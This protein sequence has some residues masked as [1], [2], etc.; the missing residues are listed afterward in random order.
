M[1]PNPSNM[2]V[3][4]I[5]TQVDITEDIPKQEIV[6]FCK[7]CGRYLQPPTKWCQYELESR[8]LLALLLKRIKGLSKVKLVDAG[9]I[10]TEPHSK[11]IKVRLSIQKEVMNS[12]ILQQ[13]FVVEYVVQNQICPECQRLDAKLDWRACIQARQKVSHKRTFLWLEQLLLK[14]GQ[15][16][17]CTSI[18][19]TPD[20]L[21]FFFS[22]RNHA[23]KVLDFLSNVVPLRSTTSKSLVS[24]DFSSNTAEYKFSYT[25]E[26]A[27]VCKDD[28]VV[29]SKKQCVSFGGVSPITLVS[30]ISNQIHL[31]DP[32]TLKTNDVPSEK[33]WRNP[34]DAAAS[35]ALLTLFWV[36]DV[37]EELQSA[38]KWSLRD[39][40]V[41]RDNDSSQSIVTRSHLG[42][43]LQPGD[44]AWGYDLRTLNLGVQ[45]ANHVDALSQTLPDIVLVKKAYPNARRKR[46]NRNWKLR[47]LPVEDAEDD[48]SSN[49]KKNK[50]AANPN[51]DMNEFM[52]ELE[53][54]PDMRKTVVMFANP[55][56][57]A[58]LNSASDDIEEEEDFPEVTLDELMND[59]S[60]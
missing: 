38:G 10:W 11:R 56:F 51:D 57:D 52:N 2:C 9:F 40:T 3:D 19:S 47:R 6:C 32:F 45:F 20:G 48:S 4:C 41:M 21:D 15:H 12:T 35:Q 55:Q 25:A 39:V 49:K 23:L 36:V 30:R 58:K 59:M 24:Q 22:N 50:N 46:K 13:D 44:S 60:M 37:E 7:S 33:Y 54:D 34:F 31:V 5:R 53:E 14:H 1:A 16:N 29:L 43:L 28:M 26:I 8:E 27:P 42:Y 17:Q 18:K